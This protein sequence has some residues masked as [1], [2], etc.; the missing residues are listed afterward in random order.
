MAASRN[1]LAAAVLL[2]LVAAAPTAYAD[3]LARGRE[4]FA[5]CSQCHGPEGQGNRMTLAPAIGGL[6][7]WYVEAQLRNFHAGKRGLE[8]EDT[9]GLRMYPMSQSLH[10]DAD[11][12]AVAA[13]VASL[14][15]AHPTPVLE[16]GDAS[17]GAQ[18]YAKTCVAC[19]GP[20]GAGNQAMGAPRLSRAS[21][22]YLLSQL[23]K[24]KAGIR[25]APGQ[26]QQAML[27]RGMAAQL[28][29]EQDM[30]DVIAHIVSL[31]GK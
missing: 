25:G 12:K 16:G 28:T 21:D 14:P 19:H 18:I 11:L 27:M 31:D 10:T 8:P 26:S 13:Y 24:F 15:P 17:R 4:I 1:S 29:S 2:A 30:R 5:L 7:E 3:D 22:W 23:E 20:D 6:D 9:G